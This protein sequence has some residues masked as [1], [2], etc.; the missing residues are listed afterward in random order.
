MLMWKMAAI[1]VYLQKEFE[2][3]GNSVAKY[4]LLCKPSVNVV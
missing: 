2:G 1:V 4:I 3:I